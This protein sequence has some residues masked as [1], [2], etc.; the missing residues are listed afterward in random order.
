[1]SIVVSSSTAEI[2]ADPKRLVDE[3]RAGSIIRLTD[4]G[5]TIVPTNAL[6]LSTSEDVDGE[7][8][9]DMVSLRS[10]RTG[11]DYTIFVS[12]RGNSRHA[13]RIKIAVDPP[14]SLDAAGKS[15]SMAVHDFKV[16]GEYLDPRVIEQAKKF[17]EVNRDVL[18]AYWN[19]E[20]DTSA[21][22]ARLV[23]P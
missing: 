5:Y 13:A 9:A 10:D 16:V 23:R 11:V 19:F 14:D 22:L 7:H 12:T 4:V 2:I 15:A 20:I 18:L 17:I 3:I 1:M 6:V 8:P 21:L